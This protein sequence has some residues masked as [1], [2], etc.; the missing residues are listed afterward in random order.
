MGNLRILPC[1]WSFS[2]IFPHFNKKME[3]LRI[4]F[5]MSRIWSLQK[6]EVSTAY[7]SGP[8]PN[9]LLNNDQITKYEAKTWSSQQQKICRDYLRSLTSHRNSKSAKVNMLPG[10]HTQ[11]SSRYC[12]YILDTTQIEAILKLLVGYLLLEWLQ[13]ILS[14]KLKILRTKNINEYRCST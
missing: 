12:K 5:W 3:R 14:R 13:K 11:L 7:L 6:T 1:H 2:S 8:L 4:S 9:I 10:V